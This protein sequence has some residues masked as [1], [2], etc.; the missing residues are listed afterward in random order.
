MNPGDKNEA[1][2][3]RLVRLRGRVQGVG[4]RDACLHHA[5]AKGITGWV[6]NRADGSVEAMLQGSRRELDAMCNWLR[7]GVPGAWVDA[8][9]LTQV[10]PPFDRL[11]RFER[12]PSL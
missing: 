5:R 4:Y 10:P 11:D 8:L 6:R 2:E 1:I 12:L 7:D 9:E 3:C